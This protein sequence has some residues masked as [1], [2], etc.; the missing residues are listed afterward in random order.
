MHLKD[1]INF[2]SPPS[3]SDTYDEEHCK[4][5]AFHQAQLAEVK[6]CFLKVEINYDVR[7]RLGV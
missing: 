2:L 6:N 5:K 4:S 3:N 7:N 1:I